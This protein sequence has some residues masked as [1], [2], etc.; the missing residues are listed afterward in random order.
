MQLLVL[1]V[2]VAVVLVLGH[3][4]LTGRSVQKVEFRLIGLV[5]AAVIPQLLAFY[6]PATRIWLPDLLAPVI[7]VWSQL[8]LLG[9]V[10]F[11]LRRPGMWLLGL[12]LTMNFVVILVNGGMMP[13][14]PQTASRL[15][16]IDLWAAG[17]RFGPGKSVVVPTQSTFFGNLADRILLPE[18]FPY[19]AAYS[20]GDI[21]IVAGALVLLYAMTHGPARSRGVSK[22]AQPDTTSIAYGD[23]LVRPVAEYGS[24]QVGGYVR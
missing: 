13:L 9:F 19:Q 17:A 12:G 5:P 23:G 14:A 18:W 10:L 1:I 22:Q 16:S 2:G 21:L 20:L 3:A 8:V 15:S 4:W 6:F 24:Q 7:L 11:N